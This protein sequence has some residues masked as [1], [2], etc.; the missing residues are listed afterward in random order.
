MHSLPPFLRLLIPL[1][2]L[3]NGLS[4]SALQAADEPATILGPEEAPSDIVARGNELS[5]SLLKQL[6][7]MLE[8]TIQQSGPVSAIGLCKQVA[9]PTTEAVGAS[10]GEGVTV[11]RTTT[12]LRN[13]KNA[14]DKIDSQVLE[15][16]KELLEQKEEAADV[17]PAPVV[18]KTADG[19]F[20]YY[21]PIFIQ[22]ACLTCHGDPATMPDDLREALS[23][24]YP[25]D[26]A[27][28]YE[29]GDFRGV[30]SV[31]FPKE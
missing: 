16:L 8:T 27:T 7:G 15:H 3:G 29:L 30:V 25:E 11:R 28:G 1:L 18:V 14:P 19:A 22:Q 26:K 23:T 6:K 20:R 12:K 17:P 10:A 5:Q 13:P 2:L 9:L 21:K 31:T 24:A 4:L